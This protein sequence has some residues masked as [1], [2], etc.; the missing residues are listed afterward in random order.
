MSKKLLKSSF[1]FSIIT[2]FSRFLG[3]FRDVVI[4]NLLGAGA[5]SDV[6][7]FANRIPNFLRRLFAE[8]A[9]SQA[10]VPVLAEY[11]D[12]RHK[13]REFIAKV[14]GTLGLVITITTL[15]GMILSPVVAA[16]F[17]TG[18]FLDWLKGGVDSI[19]YEQAS[20]LL[21]ITFP[22]LWF[23]TFVALSGAILNSLGKFSVMA[24]SPVLLNIAMI[25]SA[26]SL[27][28]Y[29]DSPNTALA[30]GVFLGG[31]LQFLFQIPFLL[32]KKLLV[33]P[34]WG[35]HDEGIVKIRKMML[36]ALFGVSV[37]QINLFIDTIIASFLMTGSISWL[38]Y[39]ERLI[40]LPLGIFGVAISTVVLPR[41]AHIF[42]KKDTPL[43]QSQNDFSN[44]LDWGVRMVVLLGIPSMLGIIA[45]AKPILI[46]L[47][48][49]GNFVEHDVMATSYALVAMSFGILSF[50]LIKIF[51]SGFYARKDMKTP[52]KIAAIALVANML[53]NSLA[54]FYSF[55]GLA[56]ASSLSGTLNAYLLYRKLS[57][58]GIYKISSTSLWL[59]VKSL[60]S[61]LI[62]CGFIYYVSPS[63]ETWLNFDF[64][65]KLY[66][67]IVLVGLGA[68]LYV[69]S[70][71]CLRVKLSIIRH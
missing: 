59:I 34:K 39:S 70:L 69:A 65:H 14:S 17:G 56:I 40:E 32:K 22:Y 7:L 58:T 20:F 23:I 31:L 2:L 4:A 29:F 46:L 61:G 35:W 12:D 27:K 10:F 6:F 52:V 25:I 48:L 50:M 54:I 28:D 1:I 3:L 30:A 63:F 18:W 11:K 33:M 60:I 37:A 38:Y 53:F 68:I 26:I 71:F 9:F 41:L 49:R 57:L 42:V 8:G 24:F 67:L 5:Y 66:Y 13:M 21:K 47:F 15:A 55:I 16:L 36:P 19:K 62:M 51:A 43:K 45:L 64:S 44:T